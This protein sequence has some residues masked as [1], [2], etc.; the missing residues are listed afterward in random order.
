MPVFNIKS[1]FSDHIVLWS[2][3]KIW[4]HVGAEV[5]VVFL[6]SLGCGVPGGLEDGGIGVVWVG[7]NVADHTSALDIVNGH[8]V[9]SQEFLVVRKVAGEFRVESWHQL[10]DEGLLLSCLICVL[11]ERHWANLV[12]SIIISVLGNGIS[13]GIQNWVSTLELWVELG[14]HS[15]D[16]RHLRD[17]S[18]ILK[19]KNWHLSIWKLGTGLECFPLLEGDNVIGEFNTGLVE[20]H[21]NWLTFGVKV[22]VVESWLSLH[23]LKIFF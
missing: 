22:E 10:V 3:V 23:S 9:A 12:M 20:R 7:E 4:L 14:K 16:G 21:S 19:L 18:S 1:Y 17:R 15:K 8:A 11:G 2:V 6:D 13:L 5:S